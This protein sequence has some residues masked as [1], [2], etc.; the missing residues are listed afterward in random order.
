M[1]IKSK[2]LLVL[3]ILMMLT[4]VGCSEK[5]DSKAEVQEITTV[6]GAIGDKPL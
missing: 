3:G 1:T 6:P 2:N 4:I 5:I